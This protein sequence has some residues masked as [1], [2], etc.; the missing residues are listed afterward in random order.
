[1]ECTE[2][3]YFSRMDSGRRKTVR[4]KRKKLEHYLLQYNTST[5]HI[6]AHQGP[7]N[8]GQHYICTKYLYL[9]QNTG[10]FTIIIT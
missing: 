2:D 10:L 5:I 9:A 6:I 4:K 3:T 8:L 1:M 7:R